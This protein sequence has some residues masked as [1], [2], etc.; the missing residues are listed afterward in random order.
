MPLTPTVV[1]GRKIEITFK[2]QYRFT[3]VRVYQHV[4][5]KVIWQLLRTFWKKP[6]EERKN[7]KVD[8]AAK[9][10]IK[11]KADRKS[12]FITFFVHFLQKERLAHS[13]MCFHFGGF[14]FQTWE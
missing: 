1:V 6:T 5:K 12:N 14:K 11:M 9:L 7:R 8:A 2:A 13:A 3:Q 10:K 4:A